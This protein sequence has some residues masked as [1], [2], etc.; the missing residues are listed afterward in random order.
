MLFKQGNALARSGVYR[1]AITRYREAAAAGL[2]TPLL[3]YNMGVAY[4]K[5]L[6]YADAEAQFT[7]AAQ[8][9]SLA[10]LALYNRGLA[11]RA[12]GAG[13]AAGESFAAAAARAKDPDL[14]S[15]AERARDAT[16]ARKNDA[17]ARAPQQQVDAPLGELYFSI[18]TRVA[19]DDN[20]YRTPAAPYVD[21]S[22]PARPLVTPVV[23]SSSFVPVDLRTL[24]RLHTDLDGS[25]FLFSYD[26]N[27]AYYDAKFAN[28]NRISQRASIGSDVLLGENGARRRWT[29]SALFIEDHHEVNFDPDDGLDRVIDGVDISHRFSYKGAGLEGAYLQRLGRW[30]WDLKLR[31]EHVDYEDVDAV[32]SYDHDYASAAA[33]VTYDFSER[34]TLSFGV[35]GYRRWYYELPARNLDG[36]LVSDN[37]DTDYQYRGVGLGM[38]RRLT[39]RI[40]LAF[41][42]LRLDRTDGFEGYYDYTQDVLRLRAVFHAGQRVTVSVGTL[43]RSFDYPNA[44]AF[45]EPTAGPRTLD[46]TG[47]EA[48]VEF[49]MKGS[50]SLWAEA[51]VTDVTSTDA[52][53]AYSQ[54]QTM[55]GVTWRRP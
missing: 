11:E 33:S 46:E 5:I 15:L 41:D 1:T 47:G 50:I 48:R 28:A 38:K 40:D 12:R 25:D 30:Q 9:E 42:Y 17:R 21:L 49:R 45:N 29:T 6:E 22:D 7:R 52:R 18:A 13:A 37:P 43:A 16:A 2:D 20:V 24:Y 4:Y 36:A 53:A 26:L 32:P 10:A 51:Y 55:L 23:Y 54:A 19:Q 34:M 31:I 8:D 14:R 35:R 39:D 44:F 3:H 27:A